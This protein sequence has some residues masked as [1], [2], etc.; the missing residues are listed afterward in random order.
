[1]IGDRLEAARMLVRIGA[2]ALLCCIGACAISFPRALANN[3]AVRPSYDADGLVTINMDY[4]TVSASSGGDFYFWAPG[5]FATSRLQIPIDREPIVV[6]HGLLDGRPRSFPFP[7][8][9]ATGR[10]TV[11]AGAQRKDAFQLIRPSGGAVMAGDPD[12]QIQEFQHM[13][14]VTVTK[15]ESGM[16]RADLEGAGWFS[17]SA[18]TGAESL[19]IIDFDFVERR[20]RPGHEGYFPITGDVRSGKDHV[21]RVVLSGPFESVEFGLVSGEGDPLVALDLAPGDPDGASDEFLGPC[22]VPARSFRLQVRGYDASGVEYQRMYSP[23]Y[24]PKQGP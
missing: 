13:F 14:L 3:T 17:L 19:A 24:T 10:F 21:C 16:W 2:I 9:T 6:A 23:L 5:E 1:M 15:P 11:F 7:V 8:D 20:G 4:Y 12:V 18:R 22:V